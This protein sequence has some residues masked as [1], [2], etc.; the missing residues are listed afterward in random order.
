MALSQLPI[1]RGLMRRVIP[2][3]LLS[4]APLRLVA[5]PA[6]GPESPAGPD[7][8]V[9]PAL[10]AL[11]AEAGLRPSVLRLALRAHARVTA[12]GS[13]RPEILTVIDY[14]LRS[15]E[16]RL[17]VLDLQAGAVLARELV[18]HGR[19]SGDEVAER[20]S[21]RPGSRQSSLGTF[22]TGATYRGTYGLSLRL[23]GLDRG[24]NDRAEARAIV[25]HGA[26]YVSEATVRRRGRV[27]RSL[28]CPALSLE[29]APRV[30]ELIRD[31]TVV[32]SYHPTIAPH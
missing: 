15:G 9:A 1:V 23:K 20:F 18:A 7:P 30:I 24:I 4:M 17:W 11:A 29:A 19:E 16:P 25:M 26:D 10:E 8:I 13:A 28:G 12:R 5:E 21:N 27:G 22:L 2:A 3:A 6:L 31:G 14:S 32:Y